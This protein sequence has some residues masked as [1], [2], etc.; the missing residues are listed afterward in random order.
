MF[1]FWIIQGFSAVPAPL[2]TP[3]AKLKS[4][5]ELILMGK[6][7]PYVTTV[8]GFAAIAAGNEANAVVYVVALLAV[9]IR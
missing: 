8:L 6:L 1:K 5:L 3:W 7:L 9:G 4:A 2:V